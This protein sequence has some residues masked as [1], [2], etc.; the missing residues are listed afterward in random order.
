MV[1]ITKLENA[2]YQTYMAV[3]DISSR[4]IEEEGIVQI[5]AAIEHYMRNGDTKYFSNYNGE[6]NELVENVSRDD[7]AEYFAEVLLNNANR[8]KSENKKYYIIKKYCTSKRNTQRFGS[9]K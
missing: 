7:M 2:V 6:R 5:K 3:T 1:D 4:K 9:A 8:K